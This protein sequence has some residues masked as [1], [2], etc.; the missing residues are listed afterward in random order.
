[1]DQIL[2]K[3]N[4]LIF[5]QFSLEYWIFRNLCFN[6]NWFYYYSWKGSEIRRGSSDCTMAVKSWTKFR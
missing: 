1:M 4:K 3:C 5:N 6:H 2:K